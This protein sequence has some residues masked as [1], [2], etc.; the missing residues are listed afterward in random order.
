MAIK[1]IK[2][3]AQGIQ[4]VKQKIDNKYGNIKG[5]PVSEIVEGAVVLSA[6][7]VGNVLANEKRKE[8]DKKNKDLKPGNSNSRRAR[9]EGN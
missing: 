2:K 6:A 1:L 7:G 4:K 5:H 8:T 3:G 9:Q